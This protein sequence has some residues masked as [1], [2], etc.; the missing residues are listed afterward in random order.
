MLNGRTNTS[1]LRRKTMIYVVSSFLIVGIIMSLVSSIPLY[2]PLRENAI[3]RLHVQLEIGREAV[4]AFR[5]RLTQ[6]ALA[7][8]RQDDLL[9]GLIAYHQGSIDAQTIESA[10][11]VQMSALLAESPDFVGVTRLDYDGEVIAHQ[12]LPVPVDG[13]WR[14]LDSGAGISFVDLIEQADQPYLLLAAPV[15]DSHGYRL[16]TDLFLASLDNLYNAAGERS[17]PDTNG[18]EV[19]VAIHGKD[20][21]HIFSDTGGTMGQPNRLVDPD[22]AAVLSAADSQ[23]Q[24]EI[25][26]PDLSGDKVVAFVPLEDS[27]WVVAIRIPQNALFAPVIRQIASLVLVLVGLL[28]VGG[29]GLWLILRPM[30]DR[31]LIRSDELERK[32]EEKTAELKNELEIRQQI[33]DE[34]RRL[35]NQHSLILDS[36]GEGVIGLDCD[37]RITFVNPAACHLLGYEPDELLFQDACLLWGSNGQGDDCPLCR[38]ASEGEEQSNL[39]T[40]LVRKDGS[41]FMAGYTSRPIY[42]HGAAVG[43]VLTFRDISERRRAEDQLRA[44]E[45]KYRTMV[46]AAID[47]VFIQSEDDSILDCNQAACRMF[48]YD[49]PEDLIGRSVLDL[50][51]EDY[52][53]RYFE[54]K[55]KQMAMGGILT[56]AKAKRKNGEVFPTEVSTRWVSILGERV[57]VA[58]VRDITYRKQI[59]RSLRISE[60]KFAKAFHASPSLMVITSLD[61]GVYIDVN[62]SFEEITGY[63]REEAVGRTIDE[64]QMF[65]HVEERERLIQQVREHGRVQNVEARICSRSGEV[66]VGLFGAEIV[67]FQGKSCL[68]LVMNDVTE[69]HERARER[70]AIATMASATRMANTRAEI[71]PVVLEQVLELMNATGAAFVSRDLQTN[72]VRVE[73]SSG[74]WKHLTGFLLPESPT[75]CHYVIVAGRTYLN[76]QVQQNRDIVLPELAEKIEALVGLPLI[77]QKTTMGALM[78][79]RMTPFTE[80]DLRTL[81]AVVEMA[82]NAIQRATLFEQTE[83]RLQRLAAL[84][85]IDLAITA[86]LDLQMVHTILL[87]QAT[88]QLGNDAARILLLTPASRTLRPLV[89]QGFLQSPSR[90]EIPLDNC[91]AGRVAIERRLISISDLQKANG[92]S[93]MISPGEGFITYHGVP[94]VAKGEVKGVLEI[95]HRRA[96]HPS[97]DWLEFLENLSDQAA[98]AIYNAELYANLQQSNFELEVAYDTTLEGWARALEL[99]DRETEGHSRRVADLTVQLARAIGVPERDIAHIRRGALLHDIGKIVVPDN[100][101]FKTGPLDEE[102]WQVMKQHPEHGAKLLEPIPFLRNAITIP[103]CHHERWD[104][105]GYPRGLKGEEIPLPARIFAVVDVWDAL[106]SDRPY[107]QAWTKQDSLDYIREQAGKQF[108]PKV[109]EI[110]LERVGNEP[111]DDRLPAE[112]APEAVRKRKGNGAVR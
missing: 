38:L 62:R 91:L 100:I 24:A 95:F 104:G 57:R 9:G 20:R 74:E 103:Y 78:V 35:R 65:L 37:N 18:S 29:L 112:A 102:E 59:D 5:T 8:T 89:S 73:L 58:F 2:R 82:A 68:L 98:I 66:L 52:Y 99:R 86:G 4:E 56:E 7:F 64:L 43:M 49:S 32:I 21:L 10:T 19:L 33:E 48:G 110:F 61:D 71:L 3:Y 54:L 11:L 27:S 44:N 1:I 25:R 63:N 72:E 79:G 26:W 67:E 90:A 94:L 40:E 23:G 84:H 69:R 14:T 92:K 107:R 53:P 101:L 28:V 17:E 60:E 108:D 30:T 16:G 93:E 51:P 12:G 76:N 97:P 45:E 87:A 81:T 83:H 34:L 85:N 50:L 55:E 15:I 41:V 13:P 106:R 105:S 80:G 109:V 22:L 42:E 46:E 36:A 31:I 47:A 70:E 6:T 96:Y 75:A 77:S 88:A 39:S 111:E